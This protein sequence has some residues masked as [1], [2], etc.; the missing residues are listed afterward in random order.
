MYL[1]NKV[2]SLSQEIHKYLV[3]W[4]LPVNCAHIYFSLQYFT[5]MFG[6]VLE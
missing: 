2:L 5:R 4:Y 3:C 1:V 6:G